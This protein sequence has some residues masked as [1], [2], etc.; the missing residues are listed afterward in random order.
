MLEQS[1]AQACREWRL[2]HLSS[3]A[4]ARTAVS[5]GGGRK[6]GVVVVTGSRGCRALH[7]LEGGFDFV[8]V[9]RLCA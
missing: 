6:Q 9:N 4:Y 3:F 8:K 2:G 5:G 1:E 7:D